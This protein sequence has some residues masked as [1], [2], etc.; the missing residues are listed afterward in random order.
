MGRYGREQPSTDVAEL[1]GQPRRRRR[2]CPYGSRFSG[3]R[4]TW[5]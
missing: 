3:C 5:C 1:S 2:R 4:C